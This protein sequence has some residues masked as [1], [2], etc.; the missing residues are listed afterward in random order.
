MLGPDARESYDLPNGCRLIIRTAPAAVAGTG[1][2]VWPPARALC[3][4]LDGEAS[5]LAGAR[6]L[7]LGSG[8]GICAI[9]AAALGASRVLLTDDDRP[10]LLALARSNVE[11]NARQYPHARVDVE[12]LEWGVTP[13]PPG[14][15]DFV[16]GSDLAY[17]ARGTTRLCETIK[18]LL[19]DRCPPRG[20]ILA[21][22][23][24][25]VE[26]GGKDGSLDEL[27]TIA[28]EQGLTVAKLLVD[29]E[30]S[31]DLGY[32]TEMAILRVQLAPCAPVQHTACVGTYPPRAPSR[33]D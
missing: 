31:V 20:V 18:E 8:T 33:S 22:Q 7:E 25:P 10:A 28:A 5:E 12:A 1:G 16:I 26:R 9:Y 17:A 2:E 11:A 15:W 3:R 29:S 32:P 30:P 6:V 4:W 21:H 23:D 14:P 24:R 13:S 27:S 19:S